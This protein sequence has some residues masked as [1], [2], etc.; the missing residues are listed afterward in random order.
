MRI[1]IAEDSQTQAVDLRRRLEAMGHEV[2]VTFNG[3]DAWKHLQSRP[4]PLVILDWMMPEMNGLE[5]CR[6]IRGELKSS[7]VYIMLL[8]A[9]THRHER[10]QGLG[11]GADDF[12]AKP[13]DSAELEIALRTAQRIIA[14]QESLRC[15]ARELE[16]ANEELARL[17]AHDELTGLKNLRGL[18]EELEIAFRQALDDHLPLSLIRFDLDH[19]DRLLQRLTP[20]QWQGL[21]CTV[22]NRLRGESREC[23][24]AARVSEH[25]FGLVMPGLTQ[26]WALPV[27]DALLAAVADQTAGDSVVTASIGLST[28]NP[29]HPPATAVQFLATC[30]SA[31]LMARGCGG[32][33]VVD[34]AADVEDAAF[35]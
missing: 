27:A 10:L 30:E 35:A 8:T 33:C 22:A 32:N 26:D 19:A 16:R 34:R 20:V 28:M 5:L 1:L 4:E 17:A 12:L 15:R 6:K 23:D 7:Y 25:G 9:K 2:V 24:I 13:V 29:E 31:L 18:Q 21:V 3:L 11:A 14:A